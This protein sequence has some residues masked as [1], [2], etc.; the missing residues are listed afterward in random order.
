MAQIN[1]DSTALDELNSAETRTLFDTADR[2]SSLGVGRIVNLPQIIVVGDQSSGKSS[3]L[4]AISHVHFPVQGG[5]CTRFATELVLRP[6]NTR[7]VTASIQFADNTRQT[8]QLQVTD[9]NQEDIANIISTAKDE[10]GLSDTG[11]GFS[12]DVLRLEIQG[13]DMYPLTLVDLPGIFHTATARQSSEGK[14]TVME[15]IESYMRK[16]N[17]IILAIICANN[18]LANQVVMQEAAKHDPSKTRTLGVITKPDLLHPGSSS[19]QEY[20]QIVQGRDAVHKLGLGWH[21][22]RNL[23]DHET[24][25]GPRDTVEEEFFSSQAWGSIPSTNRGVGALRGKLSRILHDHIRK[26]LPA[27]LQDIQDKIS[28]ME[29]EL[30]RLGEPRST[31]EDM[32]AYLI[33]IASHFQRLVQDGIRGHYIDAFFGGFNGY[34]RKLR[35]NL[36]NFNRAIRHILVTFGSAQKVI[37]GPYDTSQQPSTPEYLQEFLEVY[38]SNQSLPEPEPIT[39]TELSSQLERQAASNQGTELP[40]EVNKEIVIQ[41]FQKQAKPWKSI[42]ALHNEE[43]VKLARMFVNEAFEH[44]VG[45][46]NPNGTTDAILGSIVL[47]FFVAKEQQLSTKLEELFRPYERGY[48]RP[49]DAD[50]QEALAKRSSESAADSS[51]SE[52][53]ASEEHQGVATSSGPHNEFRTDRMI[54]AMQTF[55]DV[56]P[57][58][59]E[60]EAGGETDLFRPDVTANVHG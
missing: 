24:D 8:Y 34:H 55:Y 14:A 6:G 44:I 29:L 9:F 30:A 1:L 2:L 15:L 4:E 39:W 31:P 3:V 43:V 42:A 12:K 50:F 35:S 48:A 16:P 22:L 19:E 41:L 5:L 25:R 58:S 28:H 21:V 40:G 23:A 60:E 33:D 10:M 7:S 20:L 17:S 11:R 32:K 56:S 52:I 37:N 59:P 47:N 26:S 54:H 46:S 53:D 45:S 13:P 38:T 36:R 51:E 49:L 18:Q 27:V 57:F